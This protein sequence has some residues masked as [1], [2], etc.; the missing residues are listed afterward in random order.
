MGVL[1]S[2]GRCCSKA[3][4]TQLAVIVARIMYSNGVKAA[5]LKKSRFIRTRA[6][7]TLH[8]YITHIESHPVMLWLRLYPH[9]SCSTIS[10]Y[11]CDSLETQKDGWWSDTWIMARF[12]F[13]G[14]GFN[15]LERLQY[16]WQPAFKSAFHEEKKEQ[17]RE[18]KSALWSHLGLTGLT[19]QTTANSSHKSFHCLQPTTQQPS[20]ILDQDYAPISESES[21]LMYRLV[22]INRNQ[23]EL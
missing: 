1:S 19:I 3:R 2:P 14:I 10:D 18:G 13:P 22:A 5:K 21:F 8:C 17:V 15:L 4:T 9:S 11:I 7:I 23:P 20:V 16:P 6:W 12:T